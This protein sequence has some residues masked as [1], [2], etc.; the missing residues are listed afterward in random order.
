MKNIIN[1]LLISGKLEIIATK[2]FNFSYFKEK[3]HFQSLMIYKY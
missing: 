2:Q 3:S 1:I